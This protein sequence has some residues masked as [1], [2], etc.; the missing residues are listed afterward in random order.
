MAVAFHEAGHAVGGMA[1]GFALKEVRIW[2]EQ[3]DGQQPAGWAGIALFD[4]GDFYSERRDQNGGLSDHAQRALFCMACGPV[5]EELY[6]GGACFSRSD[7]DTAREC[8]GASYRLLIPAAKAFLADDEVW[9]A[10]TEIANAL[11]RACYLN[12]GHIEALL[13][14]RTTPPPRG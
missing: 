14:D 10:V 2:T 3:A 11:S 9:G 6:R 13:G 8:Y 1:A 4:P 12:R 7:E 5:A